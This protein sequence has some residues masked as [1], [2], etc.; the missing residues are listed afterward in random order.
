[1]LVDQ[2]LQELHTDTFFNTSRAEE[3]KK[4]ITE[5]LKNKTIIN[6]LAVWNNLEVKLYILSDFSF[7]EIHITKKTQNIVCIA[8]NSLNEV[9]TSKFAKDKYKSDKVS[10][11]FENYRFDFNC[12]LYNQRVFDFLKL[13]DQQYNRILTN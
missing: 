9:K 3:I 10:I 11:L 1:M 5:S 7:T 12:S 2:I 13:L 8:L 6:H 4:V